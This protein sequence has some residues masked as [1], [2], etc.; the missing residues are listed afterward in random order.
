[1]ADSTTT[2][3]LLTKPEVGASTDSWGNKINADLDS[4]DSLFD[5]G[6]VLKVAKGGTGISSFGTGIAT[7]LG[8][9]SSANLAAAVT[10]ET[11]SGALVFATSPTLVTPLLGTPTSGVA[12]NLTGL[13]LSTGV[14]GTLPVANGGTGQTSYTDG[15]LLIGNSTGNTLTKTTLTAGTNVTITNA[16]GAITI[17]ASGGGS[18]QWTTSGSDIYYNTGNVA[19]GAT[20]VVAS[21]GKSYQL[22]SNVLLQNVVNSQMMLSQNAVYDSTWKYITANRAAAIRFGAQNDGEISIHYSNAVGTAGGA[23]SNWDSNKSMVITQTG[24]VLVGPTSAQSG[25]CNFQVSQ[26]ITFPATQSASS[27]ANTLDDYDEYTAASSPCTLALTVS[28]VW[29]LTKVGKIVTLTLPPTFGTCAS[30]SSAWQYGVL[31]PS[32]YRPATTITLP[33]GL[34]DNGSVVTGI[35]GMLYINTAG[36]IRVY[37]SFNGTDTFT[38]GTTIGIAQDAGTSISWII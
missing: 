34:K 29:K 23:L 27:D 31:L 7:F 9:P 1:M 12:T 32:K 19:V 3:L 28:V 33:V 14:T 17:A 38:N 22:G 5:A 30:A 11:G 16:A 20:S 24:Q 4:I 25:G 18:S 15:Q 36:E 26:G 2:N 10:G 6:P 35:M 13:P 37:K 21:T 8:T